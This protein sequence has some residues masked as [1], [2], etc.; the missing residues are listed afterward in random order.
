LGG[1]GGKKWEEGS[2]TNPQGISGIPVR[3][4]FLLNKK[5][6]RNLLTTKGT[7]REKQKNTC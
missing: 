4:D 7:R 3:S 2:A 1:I 6:I 5:K